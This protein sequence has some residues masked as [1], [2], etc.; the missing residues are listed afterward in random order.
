MSG[1]TRLTIDAAPRGGQVRL[2]DGAAHY[3]G[4][5][6]RL[7]A[8]ATLELVDRDG[9]VWHG[10]LAFTD[11]VAHAVDCEEAVIAGDRAR[12][13]LVAALIRQARWEWMLEKATELG[14]TQILPVEAERS[15]VRIE[16]RRS[17]EKRER[18]QRI[19]DAATRQCRRVQPCLVEEAAP[20]PTALH[21]AAS[22]GTLYHFDEGEPESRWPAGAG[23]G[24]AALVVGPEGG[25]SLAERD[26]IRD[27]G[28]IP[29]GLGSALLRA[30]TAALAGLATVCLRRSGVV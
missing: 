13:V 18:W 19:C 26:R 29:L 23:L 25:F 7:A 14:V 10:T 6:L 4:R 20:L 16:A 21:R 2:D 27:A 28:A 12:L 22:L 5:V 11:G 24:D 17:A 1:P 15:V 3:V 8:G 30:E 9:V